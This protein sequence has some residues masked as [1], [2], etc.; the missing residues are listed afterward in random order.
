M[1]ETPIVAAPSIRDIERAIQMEAARPEPNL[2]V[3]NELIDVSKTILQQSGGPLRQPTIP[4]RVTA[5][6]KKNLHGS[7]Y[8]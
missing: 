6:I 8:Y 2:K 4:E 7:R 1:A 3:I 5:E